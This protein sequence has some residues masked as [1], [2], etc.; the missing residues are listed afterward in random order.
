MVNVTTVRKIKQADQ[1]VNKKV[2]CSCLTNY[3]NTVMDYPPLSGSMRISMTSVLKKNMK[4]GKQKIF[5]LDKKKYWF[6]L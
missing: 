4:I 3:P 5:N 6:N 2:L 1:G